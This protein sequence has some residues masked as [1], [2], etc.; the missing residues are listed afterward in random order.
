MFFKNTPLK[1]EGAVGVL[2]EL[3]VRGSSRAEKSMFPTRLC[4]RVC[5]L[6]PL[7]QFD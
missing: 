2:H 6:I 4:V 3:C 5:S 1:G 7:K